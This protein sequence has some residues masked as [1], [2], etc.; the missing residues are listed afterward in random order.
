M[1]RINIILLLLFVFFIDITAFNNKYTIS[2]YVSDLTTGEELIGATVYV[3]EIN[4]GT[5]TNLYGFYSV[6]LPAGKYNIE[7]TYIG[8]QSTNK[9]I[10]LSED[11]NLDIELNPKSETLEAVEVR[12]EA[13]DRN[14][15]RAEM[16]VEKLQ[17]KSVKKIP[18]LMGE[19]DVIKA[20]QLLPGVSTTSEGSTGYT[21]RGGGAD[22]NLVLLDEA[23]VYNSSHLLGFFSVFNNDAVKDVKLYKGDIPPEYGGRL[24]SI[25]DIRMKDGNMKNYA[26]TG[27][28]GLLSSRITAEG[29]IIKDKT[30]FIASGR[31]S[32][33]DLFLPLAKDEDVKK[34]KLYFYDLNMKVNHKFN[35]KNRL[36]LSGY[37]GRDVFYNEFARMGFGNQTFTLRWNHLFSQKLFSNLTVV[38]SKYD[39]ELGTEEGQ[40]YSMLWLSNL[41]DVSA[42]MDF[43]YYLNTNNTIKFG[44][45]S[46]LHNFYPAEIRGIGDSTIFNK[47]I[48]PNNYALEYA[49]YVA[50]EHKISNALTVKYGVRWSFFNRMGRDTVYDYNSDYQVSD[51]SMY[52]KYEPFSPYNGI[53]PRIG[54]NYMI[55]NR[56]SVKASY[57]RTRQYIHLARNS[58][59]GTPLD[60]WFPSSEQVKPQIADQFAVGYF[61]NFRNNT[62]ETSVETYY[63]DM[64]NV[65]DFKDHAQLLLNRQLEGELR[66]GEA[67]S[68]GIETMVRLKEGRL[69]GWLSYTY[70]R[71]FRKIKAIRDEPYPAFY[72]KPHD[73]SI[74]LNYDL[75][76]KIVL[77]GNWVYSTGNAVTFPAARAEIAGMVTPIYSE[78]NSY[79]MPDYH[80]LDLAVTIKDKPIN[81]RHELVLSVY[82]A[83]NRKN[84]WVINFVAEE[85]DPSDFYA[86][87]TY[88]FPFIPSVTYNFNF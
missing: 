13:P 58:T 88:L 51:T 55:N 7:Y 63:K 37:M 62:I 34:S 8:Y 29:P 3:K 61:R 52:Q 32:Y 39:Y 11:I 74:V 33:F 67:W 48:M 83:Y 6:T 50:N 77:S 17:M 75:M 21:V 84:A 66:F 54:L 68:Y 85:D 47:Y 2:G 24:S 18:A 69:N 71:T 25:L 16:S 4:A 14:I 36:F 60:I 15:K 19:V 87:K 23:T 59:A 42:K 53:E 72:D 80:R 35:D 12:A 81:P 44:A 38:K 46:T 45:I 40:P 70:S 31:R 43:N 56:N 10:E 20:I 22:Q 41:Q 26:F 73:V 76:D 86:E 82:N 28:I 1:I 9:S 5:V 30:S 57:S 49:A 65:I 79:R 78:R 27:G 64:Q